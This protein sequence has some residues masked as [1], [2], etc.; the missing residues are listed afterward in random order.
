[1]SS[2]A[3]PS[4]D[5]TRNPIGPLGTGTPSSRRG[6]GSLLPA[7]TEL[8]QSLGGTAAGRGIIER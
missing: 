2:G 7:A 6:S 3:E 4:R 1:M 5:L 8:G